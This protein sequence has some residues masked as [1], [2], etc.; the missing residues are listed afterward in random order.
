LAA[1]RLAEGLE[2]VARDEVAHHEGDALLVAAEVVDPRDAADLRLDEG[3]EVLER[4][5]RVGDGD[6]VPE[7]LD[8]E[9]L[10]VLPADEERHARGAG[11]EDGVELVAGHVEGLV[12]L[13]HGRD[14]GLEVVDRRA[15][16]LEGERGEEERVLA[17][18]GEVLG[19]AREGAALAEVALRAARAEDGEDERSEL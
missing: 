12:A 7:R 1:L 18:A 3:L 13:R 17:G 16:I 9:V 6:L 2:V 15:P 8:D 19:L 14:G 5:A 4:R 10:A 11:A